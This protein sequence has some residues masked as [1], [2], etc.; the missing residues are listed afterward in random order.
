[1]ESYRRKGT[2]YDAVMNVEVL[3]AS[4]LVQEEGSGRFS[5]IR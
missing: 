2:T 5:W 3:D 4:G 1:M